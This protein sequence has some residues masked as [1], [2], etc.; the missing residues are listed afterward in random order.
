METMH[1]AKHGKGVELL[2][3]LQVHYLLAPPC[4]HQPGS[5]LNPIRLGYHGDFIT[6]A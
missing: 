1:K 4:L 6:E 3:R 2:C 5:S